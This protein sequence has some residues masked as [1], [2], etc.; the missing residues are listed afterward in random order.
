[1]SLVK[2]WQQKYFKEEGKWL[3]LMEEKDSN[4]RRLNKNCKASHLDLLI[5]ESDVICNGGRF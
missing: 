4:S 1:M 2:L 5:D 3:K